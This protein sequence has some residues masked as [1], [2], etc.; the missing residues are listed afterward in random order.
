MNYPEER[1]ALL[2][3]RGLIGDE[4]D[5]PY[6]PIFLKSGY[7]KVMI[8]R[9]EN[10]LNLCENKTVLDAGCGLGWGT[11]IIRKKAAMIIGIDSDHATIKFCGENYAYNNVLFQV[12]DLR[13][14]TFYEGIF[15]VVLLMEVLEHMTLEDGYKCLSEIAR[16]LGPEGVLVGTTYIPSTERERQLHLQNSDNKDHLHIY[17]KDDMEKLLSMFFDQFEI[18]GVTTFVAAHPKLKKVTV[19]SRE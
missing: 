3:K 16:V 2:E 18:V 10:T 13:K 9:Y 17:T 1:F 8:Q 12:M 15:D 4:R 5:V 6:N 11:D 19:E 14:I 7:S